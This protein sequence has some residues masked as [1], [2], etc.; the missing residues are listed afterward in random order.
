MSGALSN[1]FRHR[2]KAPDCP[3]H[4]QGRRRTGGIKLK[5]VNVQ[6][7]I[8]EQARIIWGSNMYIL[9]CMFILKN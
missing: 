7:K 9:T 6:A 8:N 3:V 5:L 1:C 4:R 2:T